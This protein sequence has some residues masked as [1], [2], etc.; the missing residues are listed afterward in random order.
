MKW[1]VMLV[2]AL[3]ATGLFVACGDDA[4]STTAP[5]VASGDAPVTGLSLALESAR[6]HG[7]GDDHSD[8]PSNDTNDDDSSDD[9]SSDDTDGSSEND[10]ARG[11][12]FGIED[13]PSTDLGCVF[14]V[15]I[16]DTLVIVIEDTRIE[17]EP[18]ALTDLTPME[19]QVILTGRLGLP[20][21]ARGVSFGGG[22]VASELRIDDEIRATGEVVAPMDCLGGMALLVREMVPPL[23]FD[24]SGLSPP[25]MGS[26]VRVEGI[27]PADLVSPYRSIEIERVD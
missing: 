3:M 23:C 7:H 12:F 25:A 5:S 8:D 17:N 16:K 18:A 4:T 19:L 24:L 20:L 27:V 10:R 15:R 14:A 11:I 22:L 13:C 9:D 26:T 2:F 1:I 21:R 6:S